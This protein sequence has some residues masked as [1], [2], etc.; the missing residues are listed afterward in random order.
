[1]R[2]CFHKIYRF[3][4]FFTP[5]PAICQPTDSLNLAPYVDSLPCSY[6]ISIGASI[7]SHYSGNFINYLYNNTPNLQPQSPEGK[8]V[9]DNFSYK[10]PIITSSISG[11][12]EL[13]SDKRKWLHHQLEV[14]C[15]QIQGDFAY[16]INFSYTATSQHSNTY[17]DIYDNVKANYTQEIFTLGYKFQPSTKYFFASIGV[18]AYMNFI[19]VSEQVQETK[20]IFYLNGSRSTY[21]LNKSAYYNFTNLPVQ[22]GG[23]CYIRTKRILFKPAFYVTPCF[24]LG[25][26]FYTFSLGVG[27]RFK[28]EE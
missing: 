6:Y 26:C 7:M 28:I 5:L 21:T 13:V 16:D 25:Y 1:M 17:T 20:D 22:I 12:I 19:K 2:C 8:L 3:L 24:S 23:G 15:M 11:G 10:N 27:Y 9:P 18:N 14:G 4:F